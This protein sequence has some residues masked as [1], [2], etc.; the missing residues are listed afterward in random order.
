MQDVTFSVNMVDGQKHPVSLFESHLGIVSQVFMHF[1]TTSGQEDNETAGG[2]S[3]VLGI[4]VIVRVTVLDWTLTG[5][6]V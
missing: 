3:T 5:G 6:I 1:G 2:V 4:T